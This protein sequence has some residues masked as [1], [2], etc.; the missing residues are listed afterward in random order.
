VHSRARGKEG[1]GGG[2][3]YIA[4][5]G[6]L[7]RQRLNGI[8]GR[9]N[10]G[11][12]HVSG[13]IFG[14]RRKTMTWTDRWGPLVRERKRKAGYRFGRREDGPRAETDA[15]PDGF[16]G[17]PFTYFSFFLLFLLCFLI[18]FITFAN[19]VQIASIQFLIFF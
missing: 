7:I 8:N 19:L 10:G 15:G 17:A 11:H 3:D 4:A 2:G 5:D 14:P 12:G 18:S 1:K 6:A 13:E 9:S 16:P